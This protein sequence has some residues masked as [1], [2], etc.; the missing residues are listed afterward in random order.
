GRAGSTCICPCA[1]TV[2]PAGFATRRSSSRS[3]PTGSSSRWGGTGSRSTRDA[4]SSTRRPQGSAA[5]SR[6][7]RRARTT[8]SSSSSR[9]TRQARTGRTP[10]ASRRSRR[11]CTASAAARARSVCTGRTSRAGSEPTSVT[12]ASG[13]ATRASRSSR[14]RCLSERR[15]RSCIDGGRGGLAR[16]PREPEDG[17]MR[18]VFL[19]AS[20]TLSA[21]VVV[22]IVVQLYLIAAWVFVATGALDAHKNVGGIVVHPAEVLTFLV[23]FGA[24]W[25]SWRNIG[26]SFA[27]ALVGTIQVFFAGYVHGLHGGLALVV[28]AI[29]VYV[30][31]RE[32]R[33][34]GL[35][36]PRAA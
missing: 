15:S 10:S 1:P 9:P 14:I 19:W 18:R 29:A 36:A 7:R 8:S 35:L 2:R 24:W 16:P 21:I 30:A 13:S 11:C 20:L 25:R 22:G 17:A 28:A 6:A 23:A 31:R 27:L 12:A 5:R 26:L 4:E 3:I 34:L 32:A 33:T